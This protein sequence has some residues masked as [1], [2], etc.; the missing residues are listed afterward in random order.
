MTTQPAWHQPMKP[1]QPMENP[2]DKNNIS[3]KKL[4]S[5]KVS[6]SRIKFAEYTTGKQL[7]EFSFFFPFQ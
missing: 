7:N 5:N 2:T 1:Q 6:G 3:C 4:I